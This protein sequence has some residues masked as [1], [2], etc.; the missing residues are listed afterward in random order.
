MLSR[1]EVVS[2]F[3]RLSYTKQSLDLKP[4]FSE[5]S[6]PIELSFTRAMFRAIKRK[7]TLKKVII[8]TIILNR[9]GKWLIK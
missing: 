9:L 7:R 3:R 5:F 6:T 4:Y 2:S 8:G 1:F